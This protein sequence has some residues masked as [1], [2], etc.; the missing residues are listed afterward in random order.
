VNIAF[1][2]NSFVGNTTEL[3]DL[4]YYNAVVKRKQD[5]NMMSVCQRQKQ[6]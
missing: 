5:L 3:F 4:L 1:H 2:D 6:Y